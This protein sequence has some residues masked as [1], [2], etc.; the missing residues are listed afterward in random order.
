M[1]PLPNPQPPLPTPHRGLPYLLR[2]LELA[3][4]DTG[5]K[6]GQKMKG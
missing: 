6:E 3:S 1:T 4:H 5:G 2:H